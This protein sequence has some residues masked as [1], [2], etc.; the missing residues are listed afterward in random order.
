MT[1]F[2]LTLTIEF[3]LISV[4]LL[5]TRNFVRNIV[6]FESKFEGIDIWKWKL[7]I[8]KFEVV[9]E[10]LVDDRREQILI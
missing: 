4:R 8:L 9:I 3:W 2:I 7:L 6:Y 10:F 5:L 1:H